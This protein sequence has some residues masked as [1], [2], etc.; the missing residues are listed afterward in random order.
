MFHKGQS[1]NPVGRPKGKSPRPNIL[2]YITK[3]EI[4]RLVAKAKQMADNGDGQML[5]FL[6][7]QI[8][9]RA[10]QS[11]EMPEGSSGEI[12]ITWK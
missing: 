12:K 4:K 10:P 3:V 11:I 2:K 6:L 9:G 7:E 1:G 8:Y 5:K